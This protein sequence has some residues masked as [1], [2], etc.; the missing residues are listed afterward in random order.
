MILIVQPEESFSD[1]FLF[2]MTTSR[3]SYTSSA[4]ESDGEFCGDTELSPRRSG[5]LK[6]DSSGRLVRVASDPSLV[7]NNQQPGSINAKQEHADYSLPPPYTQ[8]QQQQPEVR[9]Y[10]SRQTFHETYHFSSLAR[11]GPME[12]TASMGSRMVAA[13]T[14]MAETVL[15]TVPV[16]TTETLLL[17]RDHSL[18]PPRPRLELCP[19]CHPRLID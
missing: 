9:V 12:E 17:T 8:Q 1:D 16:S 6:Q 11:G 3:L 2:P 7:N 15:A 4:A 13:S 10:H 14:A 19:S 18:S 5:T